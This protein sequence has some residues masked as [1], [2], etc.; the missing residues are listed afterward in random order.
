M[1]KFIAA[2]ALAAAAMSSANAV[3]FY[4]Y[5]TLYGTVCRAGLYFTVYPVQAAQPVGSF[6]P[7]RDPYGYVIATGRVTAE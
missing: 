2:I 6:C 3:T 7:V 5:G 1:K 4:H